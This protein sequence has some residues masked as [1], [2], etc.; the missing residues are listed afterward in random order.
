VRYQEFHPNRALDCIAQFWRFE[1]GEIASKV[2]DHFIPPDGMVSIGAAFIPGA[3]PHAGV[4]G[5]SDKAHRTQ[6]LSGQ[7]VVGARLKPEY[8]SP[9]L[10][11]DIARLV[12][13]F[14]PLAQIAPA[15]AEPFMQA[16]GAAA[17]GD[18]APLDRFFA[19]LAGKSP[20]PDPVVRAMAKTLMETDG[21][22]PVGALAA[23][24]NLSPRQA[25]RRF[26]AATGMTPKSFARVRRVRRACADAIREETTW[27]DLSLDAGFADQSHL[28]KSFQAVFDLPPK[29]VRAYIRRIA[30]GDVFSA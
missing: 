19:E 6:I 5:P 3:P 29:K 27:S 4:V 23:K 14:V 24:L 16:A 20:A 22:A 2:A 10:G 26:E 8:A 1:A 28:A 11:A 9:L 18:W 21:G 13:Q 12:G 25:R 15:I 30:H 7:V 17:A